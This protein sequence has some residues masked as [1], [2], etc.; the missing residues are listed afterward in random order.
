M[1]FRTGYKPDPLDPRDHVAS[2]L[3]GAEPPPEES[4]N[5]DKV[6]GVF[7]QG[8]QNSCVA[9]AVATV[10]WSQNSGDPP[11]RAALYKLARRVGKLD[12]QDGGAYIRDAFVALRK[13]GWCHEEHWPYSKPV[14]G[15]G[16]LPNIMALMEAGKR[17]DGEYLRIWEAGDA[18]VAAV[19][20]ALGSGRLVVFGTNVGDQFM[21]GNTLTPEPDAQYG[22]AMVLHSHDGDVFTG[23]NSWG[24][25]WGQG[26][27]FDMSA[28][29]VAWHMTR[30]LWTLA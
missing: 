16:S 6:M 9:N 26:G 11:A 27:H 1:K 18:R 14:T 10:L 8:D 17:W 30:D 7:D 28:A 25:G 5:R 20:R 12:N 22:H 13:Y 19:K 15:R 29:Y 4:D 23:V 3:L 21:R 2:N 24:T